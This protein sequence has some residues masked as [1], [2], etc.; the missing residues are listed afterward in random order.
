MPCP[1]ALQWEGQ[2]QRTHPEGE[3][4]RPIQGWPGKGDTQPGGQP[5]EGGRPASSG[6]L[7]QFE[8][9]GSSTA[10]RRRRR[11]P[12]TALSRSTVCS[13]SRTSLACPILFRPL[14]RKNSSV[15]DI[16]LYDGKPYP[17]LP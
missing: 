15:P 8:G 4:P 6:A 13:A 11:V 3:P 9:E 12:L 16:P 1:T 10:R 7:P 5:G 2:Q 14:Q 17:P